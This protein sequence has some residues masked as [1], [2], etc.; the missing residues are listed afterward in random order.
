[1]EKSFAE[2]RD[3]PEN[4]E[5]D[6]KTKVYYTN[7]GPYKA[8]R[9]Y[10]AWS[11]SIGR[12]PESTQSMDILTMA[13]EQMITEAKDKKFR[14]GS[15]TPYLEYQMIRENT[16]APELFL[17]NPKEMAKGKPPK[18]IRMD[19]MQSLYQNIDHLIHSRGNKTTRDAMF[20]KGV[21]NWQSLSQSE[22]DDYDKGA[23]KD[24]GINGF[25]NFMQDTMA[26]VKAKEPKT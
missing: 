7:V 3:N 9:E 15:L 6:G 19:Q 20:A 4:H 11:E 26:A 10:F 17:L 25:Y 8:A 23:E 24:V 14:P 13:Q 16:T 12:D 5:L 18:M 21:Q 22:R 1:M 2:T